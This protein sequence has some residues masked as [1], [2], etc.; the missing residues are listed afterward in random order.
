MLKD[1][2]ILQL[3]LLL[4]ALDEGLILKDC[5]SYNVQWRGA[6]PVFIDV[7]SFE[8]LEPGAPWPG[9]RQFCQL[10]LYPLMLQAYKDVPF[11]PWLRGSLEGI[12]PEACDRVMSARDHLRP[13]VLLHVHV[14]A[15]AKAALEHTTRDL[16]S[17]LQQA[18]F[19]AGLIRANITR[20]RKLI[21]S[22]TWTPRRSAWSEYTDTHGYGVSDTAAKTEFVRQATGARRRRLVWDLGAN[23]GVHSRIAAENNAYVVALDG[24]HVTIER[25]YRALKHENEHRILP[26]VIDLADPS[27]GLGWLGAERRPLDARGRPDLVLALALVHHMVISSNVPLADWV[28]WL[29]NLAPEVVVEFVDKDDP[30]TRR[31]LRNK[32]DQYEDY[33]RENFARLLATRMAIVRELP[34]QCGTRVIYHA[35]TR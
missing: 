12:P 34:L 29:C 13:G 31:L 19:N 6:R 18:G 27:P 22:L 17:D 5:S 11:Q 26:L 2:A 33:A 15:R 9:Y 14:Q 23:V 35:V 25:L 20:L 24:D 7:S 28:D 16:R 10:F 1:A 30:M 32:Q 4:A 8:P 21:S 3:D